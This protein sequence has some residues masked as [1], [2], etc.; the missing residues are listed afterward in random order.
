MRVAEE[1]IEYMNDDTPF[2]QL[3]ETDYV[4]D[5]AATY[6]KDH[7]MGNSAEIMRILR[8][9]YSY[10][11]PDDVDLFNGFIHNYLVGLVEVDLKT[12]RTTLEHVPD[13]LIKGDASLF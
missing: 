12:G 3:Q 4:V 11:D 2:D 5:V 8:E 7:V 9:N 1:L 13:E 10:I 6:M